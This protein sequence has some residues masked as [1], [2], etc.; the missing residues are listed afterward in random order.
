MVLHA[1]TDHRTVGQEQLPVIA[2]RELSLPHQ[3]PAA[4]REAR[5]PAPLRAPL[6]PPAR[7]ARAAPTRADSWKGQPERQSFGGSGRRAVP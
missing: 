5:F 2:D 6:L 3:A 4:L 7:S 1:P